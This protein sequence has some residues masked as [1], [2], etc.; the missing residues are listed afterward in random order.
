MVPVGAGPVRGQAAGGRD[1]GAGDVLLA[2]DRRA[3]RALRRPGHT[4]GWTDGPR[5]SM[6]AATTCVELVECESPSAD[7]AA[8]AR[9]A[10]V[11]ARI[12]TARSA[13]RRSTIVLD[14]AHAPALAVRRRSDP[15]AGARPPR[16][17]VAAGLAGDA[18][19]R[20]GGRRAARPGLLRHEGR[21]GRWRF[22]ALAGAGRSRRRHPAGDRRRGAR[23]ADLARADRGGGPARV[24][25]AGARGLGRRRRAQDRAQGRLA[26][27]RARGRPRRA[28][29]PRARAGRQRDAR[30]GPPGAGRS[31]RSATRRRH[32]G[33]ADR[34]ARPAPPPTRS[35]RR[36]SFAVDVRV[37]TLAE[38]D[39]VD[40]AM[41]ALRPVLPGAG[42]RGHRRPQPPA[43][44]GRGIGRAVRPRRAR[45][46]HGSACPSRSRPRSAARRTATSPPGS[47]RPT[48]DGLGAVG[49]GAHADDEHVLVDELP[50][51][52]ALLAALVADLLA[53]RR[54][55]S[56]DWCGTTMTSPRTQQ[57]G[58]R[59]R[60]RRCRLR[61]GPRG[62]GGR[63]RGPSRPASRCA[64]S[65]D[66]AELEDV[67]RLLR[68][69]LGPR[70]QPAGDPGAAARLHARR[71][72]TSAGA[73]DGDRLVGA[74]VGFF[75]AAGRGRAA[76]P[77]RRGR[78]RR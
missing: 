61:P 20:R 36:A 31:P 44:G 9:S 71:A 78:R 54:S 64:R 45:S 53:D 39:R 55:P 14:G 62:A 19:V 77:H 66:L 67:V 65:P 5:R 76:Q 32:D 70:R 18:S 58:P 63:R 22:H 50:G 40:A 15:G 6:L 29:R 17:G 47:A 28:R 23:L 21:A 35:P 1:L 69:D 37:R 7:L 51:R 27:R 56:R 34:D 25:G 38:Q 52:T 16:H 43:A 46:P 57:H 2:A 11:V 48:L 72:T 73:F 42:A 30:A 75:H 12:G 3:L 41:R 68:H 60:A 49:G 13:S 10:D 8:V 74:C 4:E 59:D 26:L 24:G 33:H